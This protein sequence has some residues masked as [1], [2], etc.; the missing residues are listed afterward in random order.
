MDDTKLQF[1]LKPFNL[2]SFGF[3]ENLE[4]FAVVVYTLLPNFVKQL[5]I[6]MGQGIGDIIT[7]TPNVGTYGMSS[8]I[9]QCSWCPKALFFLAI[10]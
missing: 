10:I 7:L 1:P 5:R 4:L 2:L 3:S 8:T 9:V 6:G